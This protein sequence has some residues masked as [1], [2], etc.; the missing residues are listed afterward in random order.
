M[1]MFQFIS[2]TEQLTAKVNMVR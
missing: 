1:T 2:S